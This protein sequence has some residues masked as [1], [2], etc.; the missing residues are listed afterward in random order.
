M[1]ETKGKVRFRLIN[2]KVRISRRGE[3]GEDVPDLDEEE[4]D[5]QILETRGNAKVEIKTF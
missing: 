2:C 1:N 5:A 4:R 3:K